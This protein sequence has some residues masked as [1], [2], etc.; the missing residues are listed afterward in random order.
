VTADK[1]LFFS[2]NGRPEVELPIFSDQKNQGANPLLPG[3]AEVN[4]TAFGNGDLK[5]SVDQL[6]LLPA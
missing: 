3:T 1:K 5:F 6:R 4:F 2:Y